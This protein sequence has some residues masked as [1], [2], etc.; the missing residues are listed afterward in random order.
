M[1]EGG[2]KCSGLRA[3]G[4][5]L[6]P[7]A[8]FG[9]AGFS[10]LKCIRVCVIDVDVEALEARMLLLELFLWCFIFPGECI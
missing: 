3:S 8:Y 4:A 5:N 2:E 9:V 10:L 6:K 7:G 1:A